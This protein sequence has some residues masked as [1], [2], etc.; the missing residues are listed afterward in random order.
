ML[1]HD[2]VGGFDVAVQDAPGVGVVDRVADVDKPPQ[3]LPQRQRPAAGVILDRL[4]GVERGDR[5]LEAIAPH[6]PHGIV[7]PAVAVGS[8]SV[9]GHD[10]GMFQ[11][12]GDLGLEYKTRA[13]DRVVGVAVEDLFERD[14]AVQLSIE[15]HEDRAQASLSVR[16]ED[17]EPPAVTGS[18]PRDV[19]AGS[20]GVVFGT[21]RAAGGVAESGL[22]VRIADLREAGADGM[23][24]VKSRQALFGVVV[25]ATEVLDGKPLEQFS[26]AIVDDPLSGQNIGNPTR[27]V[28]GPGSKGEQ[29]HILVDQAVLQGKQPDKQITVRSIAAVHERPPTRAVRLRGWVAAFPKGSG[30]QRSLVGSIGHHTG[31]PVSSGTESLENTSNSKMP[32]EIEV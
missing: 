3:Q 18:S 9:D 14:L 21:A 7:R 2:H 10:P 5:L 11:P 28:A 15:R 31:S 4:V 8:E 17:A 20:V 6:E 12:A 26:F 24:G 25:V 13:A 19:G 1:A 27:L 23:A 32:S 30:P 16:P 29:Q 22:D